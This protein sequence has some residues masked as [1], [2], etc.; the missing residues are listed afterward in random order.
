MSDT[1]PALKPPSHRVERRAILLW[2]LY[3]LIWGISVI[4][5]LVAL[6][7]FL[8][9]T[10]PWI[11]PFLWIL[12]PI[13]LLYLTRVPYWRYRVHRWEIT[14]E[15]VYALSGWIVR[16]WR[17]VPISR[18]QSIDVKKGPLQSRLRLATLKISTAAA[19]E[20]GIS[21]IG[22][23]ADVAERCSDRLTDL[24]Q[25]VPGDAT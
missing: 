4:G 14:D 11:Q 9:A 6:Y 22:L 3:A 5:V 2:T 16:E 17:I 25:T 15:A 20:G 1:L 23:D 24:T 18:I 13:Y 19:S 7:V 21:I 10:R 8:P 12:P